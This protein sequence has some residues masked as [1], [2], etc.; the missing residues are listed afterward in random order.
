MSKSVT[1]IAIAVP[2]SLF[3]AGWANND[4]KLKIDAAY[5]AGGYILSAIITHGMKNVLFKENGP[6]INIHLL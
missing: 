4:K 2:V 3:V 6:L 5:F 1:P